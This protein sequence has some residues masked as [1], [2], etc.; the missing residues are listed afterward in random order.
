MRVGGWLAAL[1]VAWAALTGPNGPVY[2]QPINVIAVFD[3]PGVG[4]AP[5]AVLTSSGVLY[6]KESPEQVMQK[7]KEAK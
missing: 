6:V 3:M 5:T 7:F 2:V 4:K 1:T